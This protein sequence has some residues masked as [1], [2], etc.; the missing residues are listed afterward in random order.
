MKYKSGK[1]LRQSKSNRFVHWASAL[2]IIIL[3]VTGLGQMPMYK[4]YNITKLPGAEWLG[5]YSITLVLHYVAAIILVFVVFYHIFIHVL[6]KQFDI[7]PKKGDMKESWQ[8]IKAMITKGEEPPSDKYLAEQRLAYV[9]IGVTVL[10]LVFS[11]LVKMLKNSVMIPDV[12]SN[13]ATGVHN[14]ATVAIILLIVAHLAA[15]AIKANRK[16]ISGMFSGYVDEEYVKHRHSIWYK[17]IK[18]EKVEEQEED[19]NNKVA[20]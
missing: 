9:A 8:I 18:S 4:R 11:G 10:A 20:L 12:I 17:K 15:F 14:V 19:V 5:D 2:S 3:I 6:L 1:I 16:L 7:M 13:I